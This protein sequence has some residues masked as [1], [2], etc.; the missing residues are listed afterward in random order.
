MSE[1]K[2]KERKGLMKERGRAVPVR[3]Q[4]ISPVTQRFQTCTKMGIHHRSHYVM[5][6]VNYR[7]QLSFF[8]CTSN[9]VQFKI[10][11]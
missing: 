9:S 1:K 2:T 8:K 10:L 6:S 11:R 5:Y 7:L 4:C 3:D